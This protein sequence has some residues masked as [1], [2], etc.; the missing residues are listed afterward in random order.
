VDWI[1]VQGHVPV[2]QP[3]RQDSSSGLTYRGGTGSP[4]WRTMARHEVDLYL[5][6]EVHDI[7]VLRRDG[8]TQIS[9]GGRL[10]DQSGRGIGNQSFLVADVDEEQMTLR[11]RR[12]RPQS[13]S[14]P[15]K[16]WQTIVPQRPVYSTTIAPD[17]H[18]VG[19]MTLTA[20]NTAIDSTG[21]MRPR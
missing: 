19:T 11:M 2:A 16:L 4:F 15:K 18:C 5:N 6:G 12:F 17:P 21:L 14:G 10:H 13:T 7:T 3:V 1:V 9:H 20:D 8:V